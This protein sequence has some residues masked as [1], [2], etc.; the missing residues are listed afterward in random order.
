MQTIES[1]LKQK[2]TK[3]NSDQAQFQKILLA[4]QDKAASEN[5]EITK[6]RSE[7]QA[8]RSE[9]STMQTIVS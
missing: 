1:E 3:T 9:R 8:L 2:V 7:D 6:L 5:S 4:E